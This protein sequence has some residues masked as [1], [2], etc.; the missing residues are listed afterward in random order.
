MTPLTEAFEVIDKVTAALAMLKEADKLL[1]DVRLIMED[2]KFRDDLF[3]KFKELENK[4]YEDI[5]NIEEFR[6]GL[7][8]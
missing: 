3:W 4:I 5:D 6:G 7:T 8:V 2:S 1:W